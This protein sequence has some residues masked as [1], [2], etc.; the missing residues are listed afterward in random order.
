MALPSLW[1]LRK[2]GYKNGMML[3]LLVMVVG[4]LIFI[5]ATMTRTYDLF[6]LGLFI[7]GTG[8]SVLQTL[9]TREDKYAIIDIPDNGFPPSEDVHLYPFFAANDW[10]AFSRST[11]VLREGERGE[12]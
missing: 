3:G 2:T 6:L 7:T 12:I 11:H 5:P 8:L 4:A 9:Y 10:Q 1:V